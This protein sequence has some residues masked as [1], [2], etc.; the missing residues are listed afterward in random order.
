MHY[1]A[2]GLTLEQ[3]NPYTIRRKL[4]E[5]KSKAGKELDDTRH[6][7]E[8][9]AEA[10]KIIYGKVGVASLTNLYGHANESSNNASGDVQKKI[11]V[12][13]NKILIN[14]LRFCDQVS[15]KFGRIGTFLGR[16]HHQRRRGRRG[17]V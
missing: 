5:L 13:S 12:L 7:I 10:C 3:D 11:D 16:D 1:T 17:L 2:V 14:T 6:V 9:L 4:F 15:L 8:S